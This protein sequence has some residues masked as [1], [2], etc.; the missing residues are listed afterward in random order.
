MPTAVEV[1]GKGGRKGLGESF[2][3][4]LSVKAL[5]RIN[6]SVVYPPV[7]PGPQCHESA[8]LQISMCWVIRGPSAETGPREGVSPATTE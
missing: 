1:L 4:G 5:L 6:T 2:R 8:H 7:C 3:G